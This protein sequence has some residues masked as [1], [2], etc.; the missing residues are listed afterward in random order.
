MGNYDNYDPAGHDD[1]GTRHIYQ[2]NKSWRQMPFAIQLAQDFESWEEMFKYLLD[3]HPDNKQSI[4]INNLSREDLEGKQGVVAQAAV[5][6]VTADT[7]TGITGTLQSW[8]NAIQEYI[9]DNDDE[10]DNETIGL[11]HEEAPVSSA[12]KTF[13]QNPYMKTFF[14][15]TEIGC[16]DAIN[17]LPQFNHDD[18]IAHMRTTYL[19]G[20]TTGT[21]E[22]LSYNCT[23]THWV[24]L[25]RVYLETFQLTQSIMW[26]S[27]GVPI[28]NS[29]LSFYK[30]A[31]DVDTGETV[32]K[33]GGGLLDLILR[34]GKFA[35][36][37]PLLPLRALK[38]IFLDSLTLLKNL[39]LNT[40][41][42]KYFEFKPTM[43]LYY[44]YVNTLLCHLAVNLR[45]IPIDS[46]IFGGAIEEKNEVT[47][48]GET[49]GQSS[50]SA[51]PT[52]GYL[53]YF[54][55][56]NFDIFTIMNRRGEF[57]NASGLKHSLPGSVKGAFVNGAKATLRAVQGWFSKFTKEDDEA[58]QNDRKDTLRTQHTLPQEGE[59][60]GGG[61]TAQEKTE[62]A[63]AEMY[64][65]I[66]AVKSAATTVLN[67]VT[68]QFERLGSGDNWFGG[69]FDSAMN[70]AL[71]L[72][73]FVGFRIDET[74]NA[75]E[76]LSNSTGQP[77]VASYL[78]NLASTTKEANFTMMGGNVAGNTNILGSLAQ[79]VID[80][81]NA[82]ITAVGSGLGFDTAI[83]MGKGLGYFDIP[84]VWK[85]SN[86]SKSYNFDLHFHS[87]YG[88]NISVFTNIYIPCMMILALAF[89]RSVGR[90]SYTSP[91]LI[92]AYC[93][94]QFAIPCGIIE[95]VNIS[96]GGSEHGWTYNWLPTKLSL[97]FSIKDLSPVL[98][99]AIA[100]GADTIN[101][102]FTANS[103][104]QEYLLT[105]GGAGLVERKGS[106]LINL[107][108]KLRISLMLKRNKWLN[109]HWYASLIGN[110]PIGVIFGTTSSWSAMGS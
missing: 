101:A 74:S 103:S 47:P 24:S 1:V 7:E 105:L 68:D 91:F 9:S 50:A 108:R 2:D 37:I 83:M 75:S 3:I 48:G 86:F 106:L 34:C 80:G 8:A 16:N 59:E 25:G 60:G 69:L 15:S 97:S 63:Q 46:T 89:P 4:S 10:S 57:R 71:G 36:T 33:G 5:A 38:W 19:E 13:L 52:N 40:N 32:H 30:N 76:S 51:F 84:D 90:N 102:I 26:I 35:L 6:N 110:S 100:G 77:A 28:Y 43:H 53:P 27:A 95:S 87:P 79:G 45:L 20:G 67:F 31:Y 99:M 78:H 41:I 55:Q 42:S 22:A 85:K 81:I 14:G 23:T 92:Q 61:D 44:E 62:D 66:E 17:C 96:R 70:T 73:A 39:L 18:D 49:G 109:K 65:P 82:A 88:D 104:M 107:K 72:T 64:S 93:K 56:N 12:N 94:G 21:S 11:A 58:T 29:M 54:L 98:H